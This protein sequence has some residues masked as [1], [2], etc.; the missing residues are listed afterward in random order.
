MSAA[1]ALPSASSR[2][3]KSAKASSK[4]RKAE[5]VHSGSEDDDLEVSE[6]EEEQDDTAKAAMGSVIPVDD[7]S[8]VRAAALGLR[9]R[10]RKRES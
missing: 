6:D 7:A 8:L 1:G 3:T 2:A 9:A 5:S 10:K 4:G